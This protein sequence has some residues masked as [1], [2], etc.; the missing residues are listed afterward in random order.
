MLHFA[1]PAICRELEPG[2]FFTSGL[3]SGQTFN[4]STQR[5]YEQVEHP[6]DQNEQR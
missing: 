1:I 5:P 4:I 3:L 2:R 6:K